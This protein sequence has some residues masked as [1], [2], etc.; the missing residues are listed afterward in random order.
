MQ[1]AT[2]DIF[3]TIPILRSLAQPLEIIM[4]TPCEELTRF[5]PLPPVFI[6]LRSTMA[7]SGD[8]KGPQNYFY[9]SCGALGSIQRELDWKLFD[10][11]RLQ[12]ITHS[13]IIKNDGHMKNLIAEKTD[14]LNNASEED[15]GS[16]RMR[17]NIRAQKLSNF[18]AFHFSNQMTI[19]GLWSLTEQTMGFVYKEMMTLKDVNAKSIKIPYRFD[20]FSKKFKDLGIHLEN[21]DTFND[22]DECRELN[23]SIKHGH[24]I[25]SKLLNYEYFKPHAGKPILGTDFQLQ[26]YMTG[27]IQFLSNLIEEGNCIID[28][29]HPK[30]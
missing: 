14:I 28:P 18:Q 3:I 10:F 1:E 22:A 24:L 2:L 13:H 27:V 16:V 20:E 30:N 6:P 29:S 19:I 21:L 23:N 7:Y 8:E 11:C 12:Q 17:E 4:I 25:E 15:M 9:N 26:R 5:M